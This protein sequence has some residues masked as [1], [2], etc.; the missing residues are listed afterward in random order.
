MK[1]LLQQWADPHFVKTKKMKF[2]VKVMERIYLFAH[3]YENSH[4]LAHVQ[5]VDYMLIIQV[6]VDKK[7]IMRRIKNFSTSDDYI[8]E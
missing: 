3:C 8:V 7:N 2:K 6:T 4:I 1:D 5:K